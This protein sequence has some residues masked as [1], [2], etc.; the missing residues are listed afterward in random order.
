MS[1]T[2]SN[3]CKFSLVSFFLFLLSFTPG[4]GR[5]LVAGPPQPPTIGSFSA[6]ATSITAGQSTTLNWPTSGA[7]TVTIDNG[8]GTVAASGSATVSPTQTTTYTLT[9]TG[10][11]GNSSGHVTVTVNQPKPTVT[12]TADPTGVSPGQSSTL[13]VT[14]ANASG[15]GV[16]C[17]DSNGTQEFT[18]TLPGTGGT[19]SVTPK[20]TVT[21]VATAKGADNQ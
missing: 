13:T 5:G 8:V 2:G 18:G 1:V 20:N 19:L 3:I 15:V 21:C 16:V 9:A 10:D 17:S 11:G 7:T 12:I 4:C 14:A 6:A